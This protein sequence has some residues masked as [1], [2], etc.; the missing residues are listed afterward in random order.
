M[1]DSMYCPR[2]GKEAKWSDYSMDN[3][4]YIRGCNCYLTIELPL[5][6]YPLL[7]YQKNL[8]NERFKWLMACEFINIPKAKK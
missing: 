3:S 8:L 4:H 6:K 5:S 2:C 7:E 1:N